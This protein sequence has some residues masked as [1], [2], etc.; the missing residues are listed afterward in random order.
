V[1]EDCPCGSGESL[2]RCCGRLHDGA[3]ASD[4]EALMRSR[5]SAFVLDRC[6]YLLASWHPETRP[7]D[8]ESDPH[9]RWCRL[10]VLGSQHDGDCGRVH[11]RATWRSGADW[12]VLEENSLF[13]RDDG[14]WFYHSGDVT[15]EALKPGRNDACPC[16]S[17]RKFKKCCQV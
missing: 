1:T 2:T 13:L 7:A 3:V 11:F 9:T 4:P 15:T 16:G 5:Y 17:G 14:H 10:L 6:D 8:L 12:G